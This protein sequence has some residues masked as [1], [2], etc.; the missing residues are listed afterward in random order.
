MQNVKAHRPNTFGNSAYFDPSQSQIPYNVQPTFYPDQVNSN[1]SQN[2]TQ[3]AVQLGQPDFNSAGNFRSYDFAPN[4]AVANI[5][6]NYGSSVVGQG[7]DYVQ[8]SVDKYLSS[9]RVK[10]YFAVTN[11]Y[12]AKKLGL[13]I[14]PFA[15]TKWSTEFDPA[16]PVPPGDDLNAPDLYI[17]IMAFLTYI[18]VTGAVLGVQGRFSPEQLGILASEALGWLTIEVLLLLFC[19]YVLNIQSSIS[20]LDLIAFCGYKFVSM[21]TVNLSYVLLDLSGY[22]FSLIYVSLSLAFF[23]IRSLRMKVLPHPDAYPSDSNKYRIYF[24]LMI[25]LVQPF[26]MWWLTHR[27]LFHPPKPSVAL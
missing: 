16:G 26:I 24:L 17:P 14:F 18:L 4:A 8:K 7:A 27:V 21:I 23:L 2:S 19:I 20:Y 22:Y 25:A 3:A 15:H 9:S 13:V 11:S 12:V 6:L 10:Y 1:V 5:A